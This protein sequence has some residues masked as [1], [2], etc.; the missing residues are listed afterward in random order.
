MHKTKYILGRTL[1]R[2]ASGGWAWSSRTG[3]RF[4]F[5][6]EGGRWTVRHN[7]KIIR[8]TLTLETAVEFVVGQDLYLANHS[9]FEFV[10][11]EVK[12]RRK[13]KSITEFTRDNADWNF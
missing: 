13:K 11:K 7:R 8:S 4:T 3:R 6:N 2:T 9:F 12:S 5:L 1:T 10:D